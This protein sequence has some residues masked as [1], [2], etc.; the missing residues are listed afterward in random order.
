MG[1]LRSTKSVFGDKVALDTTV[2]QHIL[3]RHPELKK[4]QNLEWDILRT[5]A[6]P[7]FVFG[8]RYGE[9]IAVKKIKTGVFKGKWIVVP[10]D[11]GG[12][13][14]TAF[15]IS[16]VGRIKRMRVVLWKPK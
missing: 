3:K 15:I 4:L 7:D 13:I 14:K 16:S 10:Y 2:P 1:Q 6:S 5:V 12:G 9:N 11:E 8:G